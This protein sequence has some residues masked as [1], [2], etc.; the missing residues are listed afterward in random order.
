[1]SLLVW[2]GHARSGLGDRVPQRLVVIAACALAVASVG[3]GGRTADR[4]LHFIGRPIVVG[5][6]S[7]AARPQGGA[8]VVEVIFHTNHRLGTHTRGIVGVD[9]VFNTAVVPEGQNNKT[10]FGYGPD[11][12]CYRA[13]IYLFGPES[14]QQAL[15]DA[16]PGNTAKVAVTDPAAGPGIRADVTAHGPISHETMYR[17]A[18][19]AK[20][21]PPLRIDTDPELRVRSLGITNRAQLSCYGDDADTI[22]GYPRVSLCDLPPRRTARLPIRR[23]A[24]ITI[25]GAPT[26]PY[27]RVDAP[28]SYS[29][30]T[31][32]LQPRRIKTATNAWRARIPARLKGNPHGIE[33]DL[34]LPHNSFAYYHLAIR[35]SRPCGC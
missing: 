10:L 1:M 22:R 4:D 13:T 20:C 23:G 28:H 8:D 25:L 29:R 24:P 5:F 27:L 21:P 19:A 26:R 12:T 17:L 18:R 32:E 14:D 7:V 16:R 34:N 15:F 9:G 11:P 2:P 6:P 33:I 3:C 30:H 35:T 31:R